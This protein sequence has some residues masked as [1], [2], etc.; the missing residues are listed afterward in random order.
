MKCFN[1]NCEIEN[2]TG[3]LDVS[4]AFANFTREKEEIH[5]PF[6]NA[7]CF[8]EKLMEYIYDEDPKIKYCCFQDGAIIE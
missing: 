5:Y 8:V 7:D 1:C 4:S 6:C 2:N 3:F